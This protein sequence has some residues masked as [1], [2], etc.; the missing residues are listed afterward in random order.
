[1]SLWSQLDSAFGTAASQAAQ[2]VTGSLDTVL[3]GI[4]IRVKTNLGPEFSLGGLA[5][6]PPDPS[7]PPPV[8]SPTGLLDLMGV[9]FSAR[10]VD[11]GGNTLTSIG[12]PP[13]TNPVLIA[14]YLLLAAAGVY[15]L[16]RGIGA[17]F[18]R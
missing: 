11:A 9:K 4:D 1:M 15:F 12:T 14:V 13:D 8:P 6:A 10:L 5:S 18:R 7:Q 17:T 2:D 16:A 3:A